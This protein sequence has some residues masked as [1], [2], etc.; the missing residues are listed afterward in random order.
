[1]S[2]YEE[3]IEAAAI[4]ILMGV[5]KMSGRELRNALAE[6]IYA[7]NPAVFYSMMARLEDAGRVVGFYEQK[8]IDGETVNVR[9]YRV[10]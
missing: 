3:H 6:K 9:M 5:R 8:T 4:K 1:M 2:V 10:P 7:L